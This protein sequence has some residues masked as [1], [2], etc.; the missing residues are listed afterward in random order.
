M[1]ELD[2]AIAER[3]QQE[4]QQQALLEGAKAAPGVSG[5]VDDSSILAKVAGG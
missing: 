2:A 3:E 4:A 1:K 5:P